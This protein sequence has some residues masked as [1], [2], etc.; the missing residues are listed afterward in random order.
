MFGID[1]IMRTIVIIG[2]NIGSNTRISLYMLLR[3][4]GKLGIDLFFITRSPYFIWFVL[5][6]YLCIL[7]IAK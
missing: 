7:D 1:Q 5:G 3:M 4:F 6:L 2:I